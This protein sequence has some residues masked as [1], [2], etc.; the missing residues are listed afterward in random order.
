MH[1]PHKPIMYPR[2]EIYK[3]HDIPNQCYFKAG[4]SETNKNKESSN[5]L[6]IYCD[7]DCARDLAERCSVTLKCY[8]FNVTLIDWYN[9]KNP[10]PQESALMQKQYQCKQ[11]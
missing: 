7:A 4:D 5:F 10:R 1:H 8:L 9:D 2:K 11:E 6:H 3:T